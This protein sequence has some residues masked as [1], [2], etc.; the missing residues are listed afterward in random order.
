[1]TLSS[2]QA[3]YAAPFAPANKDFCVPLAFPFYLTNLKDATY[4]D[5]ALSYEGNGPEAEDFMLK[6]RKLV[7]SGSYF[8]SNTLAYMGVTG[9]AAQKYDLYQDFAEVIPAWMGILLGSTFL[10]LLLMTKSIVVPIKAI[11]VTVLSLGATLGILEAVIPFGTPA[12]QKGLD[13]VADGYTDG[14]NIIFIFSIAY[15]LSVDYGE[16]VGV[17]H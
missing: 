12:V 15:A 14:S 4:V 16:S 2:Y 13:F 3:Q 8:S 1:M 5:V 17:F 10:L 6:L 11:V 7:S 9:A